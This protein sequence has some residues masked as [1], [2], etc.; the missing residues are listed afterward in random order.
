MRSHFLPRSP[1]ERPPPPR[2]DIRLHEHCRG[3]WPA[4]PCRSVQACPRLK[5][6]ETFVARGAG[7]V[8]CRRFTCAPLV[9]ST[10][11]SSRVGHG[12]HGE[13]DCEIWDG[14]RSRPIEGGVR[15]GIDPGGRVGSGFGGEIGVGLVGVVGGAV[16]EIGVGLVGVVGGA[17]GGIVGGAVG[18]VGCG[19]VGGGG[20]VGKLLERAQK[21]IQR[22]LGP[23]PRKV[24]LSEGRG[25]RE[26][27]AVSALDSPGKNTPMTYCEGDK[28]VA[29]GGDAGGGS[30]EEKEVEG[31]TLARR[32][33]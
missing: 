14:A 17:V 5:T 22:P 6:Q 29:S 32:Q 7:G 16:G 4:P 33:I 23:P 2:L 13:L 30:D 12:E 15:R 24:T 10:G 11:K 28:K 19:V 25:G 1:P 8:S 20:R 27:L 3:R 21:A 26:R 31:K 9:F 18:V